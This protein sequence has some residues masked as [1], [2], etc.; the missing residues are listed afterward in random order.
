MQLLIDDQGDYAPAF[1]DEIVIGALLTKDGKIMHEQTVEL[2][3]KTIGE[4]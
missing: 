3:N 4:K 1:D 2:L